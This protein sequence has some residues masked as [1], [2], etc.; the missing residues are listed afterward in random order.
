MVHMLTILMTV[1]NKHS[2]SIVQKMLVNRGY[3]LHIYSKSASEALF[4]SIF[5]PMNSL[6]ILWT[7]MFGINKTVVSSKCSKPSTHILHFVFEVCQWAIWYFPSWAASVHKN[8]FLTDPFEGKN[9]NTS[10][11]LSEQTFWSLQTKPIP[12]LFG[13][14]ARNSFPIQCTWT[15]T[16]FEP[17]SLGGRYFKACWRSSKQTVLRL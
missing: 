3:L 14:R 7:I 10:W 8:S 5:F 12:F 1:Y 4:W 16:Y 6:R 9:F 17:T 11:S 15:N 2:T 13:C